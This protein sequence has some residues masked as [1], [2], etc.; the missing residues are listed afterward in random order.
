L[1]IR[2]VDLISKIMRALQILIFIAEL[3]IIFFPVAYVLREQENPAHYSSELS[4][5]FA[6]AVG[7]P[8]HA[9]T[10][11]AS[12]P[13]PSPRPPPTDRRP[14]LD[15]T[16]PAPETRHVSQYCRDPFE[17][18]LISSFYGKQSWLCSGGDGLRTKRLL[19]SSIKSISPSY[20]RRSFT[21]QLGCFFFSVQD[22]WISFAMHAGL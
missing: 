21:Y 6:V 3:Q 22:C 20:S 11:P 1:K 4:L 7:L 10:R 14:N 5:T 2:K 16:P 12:S 19:A 13:F 9:R 8:L 18:G 17:P 15:A